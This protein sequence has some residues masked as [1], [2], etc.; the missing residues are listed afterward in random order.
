MLDSFVCNMM[1]IF[2]F[3]AKTKLHKIIEQ[4]IE[5]RRNNPPIEKGEELL[6]DLLMEYWE[7]D[8]MTKIESLVFLSGGNHTTANC[9]FLNS[10]RLHIW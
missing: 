1:I 8:E 7:D 2:Y 5:Q 3:T 10:F 6:I 4:A 9:M